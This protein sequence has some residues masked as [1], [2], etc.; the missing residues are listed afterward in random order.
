MSFPLI[1]GV[2]QLISLLMLLLLVVTLLSVLSYVN[3]KKKHDTELGKKLDHI[4]ELLQDKKT[5]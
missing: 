4:I 2:T 1:A 3:W 5:L